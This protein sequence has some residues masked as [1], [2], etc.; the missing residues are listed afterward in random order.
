MQGVT[1]LI[2]GT[3]GLP[4]VGGTQRLMSSEEPH[5]LEAGVAP[6]THHDVVEDVDA[7]QRTRRRQTPGEFD[8]VATR[9][10]IPLGWTCARTTAAALATIAALK[11]SRGYVAAVL[12]WG[13]GC[14]CCTPS[15]PRLPNTT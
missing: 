13:S 7:D 8:V 11:T 1:A 4:R 3:I 14:I 12:M 9:C 15:A 10:G 2:Q 5:F 6:V